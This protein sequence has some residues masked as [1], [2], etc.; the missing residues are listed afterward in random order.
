M[1]DVNVA[2]DSTLQE[3]KAMVE[4]IKAQL[5]NLNLPVTNNEVGVQKGRADFLQYKEEIKV[6]IMKEAE[7]AATA[8]VNE[9]SKEKD[10]DKKKNV[11]GYDSKNMLKPA[12]YDG[13]PETF[14]AWHKLFVAQLAALSEEC[15]E[16]LKAAS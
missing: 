4:T 7:A 6:E 13:K 3:V 5:E 10:V 11:K 1:G 8:A 2:G 9:K 14:Q 15:D 16:I 12:T